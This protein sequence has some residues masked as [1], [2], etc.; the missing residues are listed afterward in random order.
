L[1][2]LAAFGGNKH[3]A[4]VTVAPVYIKECLDALHVFSLTNYQEKSSLINA[5]E[6]AKDKY[7]NVLGK[8]RSDF[9]KAVRL[10]LMAVVNFVAGLTFG[11]AHFINYKQTGVALFFD[12]PTSERCLREEHRILNSEIDRTF[13]VG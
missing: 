9:S 5:L 11:L 12:A 10:A 13:V 2:D 1:N 8:D 4:A 7:V 6:Q 3:Q